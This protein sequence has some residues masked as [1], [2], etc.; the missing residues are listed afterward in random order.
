MKY[1]DHRV[2]EF[3][4]RHLDVEDLTTFLH[5]HIDDN[6]RQENHFRIVLDQLSFEG[7]GHVHRTNGSQKGNLRVRLT[8]DRLY[9]LGVEVDIGL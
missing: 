6:E 4:G 2:H 8:V 7:S 1:L 9:D 5:R 3:P